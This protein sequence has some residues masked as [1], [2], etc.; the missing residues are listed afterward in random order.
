MRLRDVEE[1]SYEEIM[2][3]TGLAEGTVK[4]RLHRARL[5]LKEE[6]ARHTK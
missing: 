1:L 2:Q 4:S 5:V 3:V 6:I